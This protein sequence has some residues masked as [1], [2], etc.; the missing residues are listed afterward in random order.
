MCKPLR[1][2]KLYLAD[3]IDSIV[4]IERYTHG[5]TLEEFMR[6]DKTLDAV[7]RNLEVIGEASKNLPD[8]IRKDNPR[9][10]WKSASEMRNKLI[11]EYFGVSVR[12]V[13]ETIKEDLPPLRAEVERILGGLKE[14]TEG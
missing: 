5:T 3:I 10:D 4:K 13:W 12:I 11:H 6:D 1:D 14:E 7:L 2:A 9:V 8:G